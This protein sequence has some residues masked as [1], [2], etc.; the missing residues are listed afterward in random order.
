MTYY[1]LVVFVHENKQIS[2]MPEFGIKKQNIKKLKY[3]VQ[4]YKL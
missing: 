4:Y 3:D 1:N 2:I